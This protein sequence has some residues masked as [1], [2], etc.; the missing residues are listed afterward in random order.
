MAG[1]MVVYHG[2]K[3]NTTIPP[4]D[5]KDGYFEEIHIY[6]S[7]G[8]KLTK[9]RCKLNFQ[10]TAQ[11]VLT[12]LGRPDRTFYKH[13]DK[14]RIHSWDDQAIIGTGWR[15]LNTRAVPQGA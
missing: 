8:I 11:D 2:E 10:S 6:A 5:L 4:L 15:R 3:R 9:R 12:E 1:R 14:M 13:E 7:H